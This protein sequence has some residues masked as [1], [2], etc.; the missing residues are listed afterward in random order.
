MHKSISF[1]H[2]ICLSKNANLS[3]VSPAS[4]YGYGVFTTIAI[5]NSKPFLWEKHWQRVCENALRLEID[6]TEFSEDLIHQSLMQLIA[7]N[8][9]INGRARLTFFDESAKGF[10]QT[11]SKNKTSLLITTVDMRQVDEIKLIVSPYRINSTSPLANI[12]SCNYLENLLAIEEAKKRNFNEAIRLNE[13]GEIASATMAN[14]FWCK[15]GQIFT[16]S[17]ETGCL[18]GT[19]REFLLENFE[20]L[21]VVEPIESLQNADEIFLTSS[22]IG[23]EKVSKFED[24][25]LESFQIAEKFSNILHQVVNPKRK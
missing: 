2:Q 25:K 24:K 13:K 1:N 8:S 9:V 5:Y 18:A 15:D 11:K 17:L 19:M 12:K 21:E 7:E 16:P 4:L 14:I 3:A 10:W 20:I 23:I 22:G 6:L